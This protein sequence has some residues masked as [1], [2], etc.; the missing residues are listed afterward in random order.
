QVRHGP[1]ALADLGATGQAQVQA[2][3]DVPVLVGG[4]PLL[5]LHGGLAN[6]RAGFHGGVDFV[7]G[8]VEEAGVDEHHALAGGLDARLEVDGGAALFVHDADLQ[9][10]AGQAEDVLDAGEDL[11]GEGHFF[12]TVHLRLDD[13]DRAGAAVLRSEE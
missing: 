13:V 11:A 5:G 12:R 4:D 2:V 3:V 6:H 1:H 7:T 8:T 10:V 9:G